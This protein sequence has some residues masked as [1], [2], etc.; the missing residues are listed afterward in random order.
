MC[1]VT[2]NHKSLHI[3]INN[4][5]DKYKSEHLIWLLNFLGNKMHAL[6]IM[7]CIFYVAF[8]IMFCIFYVAFEITVILKALQLYFIF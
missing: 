6:V 5:S 7:S 3:H 4:G 1:K 8:E 2:L